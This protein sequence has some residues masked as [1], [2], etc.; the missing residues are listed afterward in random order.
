VA[1]GHG[2]HIA[3]TALFQLLAQIGVGAAD[4][5]ASHPRC[6]RPAVEGAHDHLAGLRRFDSESTSSGTPA[7]ALLDVA[8]LV[9]HQRGV[10]SPTCSDSVQQLFTGRSDSNARIRSRAR[11]GDPAHQ[12]VEVRPPPGRVYAVPPA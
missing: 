8:G 1:A 5:I 7:S 4:L 3:D 11:R 9:Y 6:R 2:Q 12:I 10:P